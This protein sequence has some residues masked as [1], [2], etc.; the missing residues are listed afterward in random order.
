MNMK[1]D[2]EIKK[3]ILMIS[4]IL[5]AGTLG[6]GRNNAVLRKELDI[7]EPFV[8]KT[9]ICEWIVETREPSGRQTLHLLRRYEPMHDGKIL[10]IYQECRELNSQ[11]DGY[12]YYDPDKK[13]IAFLTLTNNG[14]FSVGNVKEEGGKIL[15]Y[16]H[17]TFPDEKLEFKNTYELT[18]SGEIVDQ[19][20]SFENGEWRAGH[21]RKWTAK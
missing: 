11:T 8:G 9:W 1:G 17:V 18:A 12:Y 19:F 6:L 3:P 4:V 20:F 14:N 5:L 16:G 2:F 7:L 13:E 21:S 10:K 15:E